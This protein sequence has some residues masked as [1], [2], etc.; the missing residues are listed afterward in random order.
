MDIDGHGDIPAGGIEAVLQD[1]L[2]SEET[3]HAEQQHYQTEALDI[4]FHGCFLFCFLD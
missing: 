3:S 1:G 4:L 2:G